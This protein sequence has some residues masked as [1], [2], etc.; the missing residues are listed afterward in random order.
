MP[1]EKTLSLTACK[2]NYHMIQLSIFHFLGNNSTLPSRLT[3]IR[4]TSW[5]FSIDS[6]D[7]A[8]RCRISESCKA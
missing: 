6:K 4:T 2:L 8:S 3:E 7:A 5:V 1:P